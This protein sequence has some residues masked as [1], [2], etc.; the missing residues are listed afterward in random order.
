MTALILG[1]LF[2]PPWLCFVSAMRVERAL[3]SWTVLKGKREGE[4]PLFLPPSTSPLLTSPRASYDDH[5]A[6]S[7][8]LLV[9][10]LL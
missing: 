7:D 5:A 10:T 3:N 4:T 8:N 1:A 2:L 9:Y 6:L